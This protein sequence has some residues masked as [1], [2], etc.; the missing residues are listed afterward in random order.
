MK[1]IILFVLIV[2]FTTCCEEPQD[3]T[4]RVITNNNDT[5]FVKANKWNREELGA[6][7]YFYSNNGRQ[8]IQGVRQ[9][10]LEK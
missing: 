6:G 3:H 4:Y 9:I 10:I 5:L 8:Y 2:I 1:K 7:V